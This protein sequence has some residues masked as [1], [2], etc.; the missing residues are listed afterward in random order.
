MFS[1]Y[2]LIFGTRDPKL[3][4]VSNILVEKDRKSALLIF[5]DFWMI[6]ASYGDR[7]LF[8]W[9]FFK[10]KRNE[11]LTTFWWYFEVNLEQNV[12]FQDFEDFRYNE[13]DV[14]TT[15]W[16]PCLNFLFRHSSWFELVLNTTKAFCLRPS[17]STISSGGQNL[18]LPNCSVY[19]KM[20][21]RYRVKWVCS[22]KA[23][24][25]PKHYSFLRY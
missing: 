5:W 1:Y 13:N 18:P 12:D 7:I 24:R 16:W 21:N 25:I 23:V 14:I 9:K 20:P 19:K 17:G 10:K 11:G 4:G 22:L 3:L 2:F 8:F 15:S 6:L